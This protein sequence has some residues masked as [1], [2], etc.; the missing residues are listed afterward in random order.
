MS[1][2][3][4]I[5]LVASEVWPFAKEGELAD[6]IYYLSCELARFGHDIRVVIPKYS[7]VESKR[8]E[9]KKIEGVLKVPMGVIG[10]MDCGVYEYSLPNKNIPE[11]NITVYFVDRMDMYNLDGSLYSDV[12]GEAYINNDN[13]FVL[14]SRASLELCKMLNFSPD[15]V[16]ANDWNTAAVPVF[17]KTLYKNDP[18]LSQSLSVFTIHNLKNQGEFYDGLMDVLSIGWEHFTPEGLERY[19]KTNLLKGGINYAD[20]ITTPSESYAREIQTEEFGVGLGGVIKNRSSSL[21]GI[22][23]GLDYEF[24]DPE[25]DSYIEKNYSVENIEGKNIC[26]L[27]LQRHMGL[28]EKNDVPIIG[29]INWLVKEKGI[30]VLAESVCQLLENDVQV[31]LL[32]GGEVWAHSFFS[33][34]SY[35]YPGK[36]VFHSGYDDVLV[37][38]IIAGADLLLMSSR[39]E[40]CGFNQMCSMRYGTLPIVRGVGG[41]ND[42][43]LNFN[44]QDRS[45][46]GFKFN[47]LT[48]NSLIN[49]VLWALS[50]YY[51]HSSV[52]EALVKNAMDMRFTW[53]KSAKKYE[54]L[55]LQAINDVSVK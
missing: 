6:F 46:T 34:I 14:L 29:V 11:S 7:Q 25:T 31:V 27:A 54:T 28:D 2:V 8:F 20:I 1:R 35:R 19:G 17:L 13:R 5:L 12:H 51:D 48:V 49:T 26:K 36:F 30:D 55:Y 18:I 39:F 33:N 53:Q 45:G 4:K 24:W 9:L 42:T 3:L 43:V 10:D 37:H 47:D 38:N 50:T 21:F 22:L 41:L 52:F 44:E 40:P 23:N 16:H 32:G 15:I